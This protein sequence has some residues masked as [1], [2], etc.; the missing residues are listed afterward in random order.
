M[1][2]QTFKQMAMVAGGNAYLNKNFKLVPSNNPLELHTRD[3][4]SSEKLLEQNLNQLYKDNRTLAIVVYNKGHII[5]EKYRKPVTNSCPIF[6]WSMSKSLVGLTLGYLLHEGKIL[7]LD[8]PAKLYSKE[9]EGTVY[10]E[11]SIRNLLKMSSGVGR[12]ITD[13]NQREHEWNHMKDGL[14]S[15]IEHLHQ[16]PNIDLESGKQFNYSG[17]DTEAVCNIIDNNGGFLNTFQ[18]YIWEPAQT[19][20]AG[21]WM[22]EKDDR[23]IAQAGFSAVAR[24]WIRIGLHTMKEFNNSNESIR[25]YMK[26]ATSRQIENSYDAKIGFNKTLKY[27][28]YQT[29]VG[30]FGP[31][32]SYWFSGS[33]GLRLGIDPVNEKMMYVAAHS[34]ESSY[35]IDIY[36]SFA[37]LQKLS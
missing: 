34:C 13:G 8:H 3:I 31:S 22:L 2:K 21:Y 19:E 7:D 33:G 16:F 32:P 10:G 1:D 15:T 12:S 6:S 23:V 35:I 25:N 5:Y 17:T 4:D 30:D 36:K 28:G 20:S 14:Y 9:L 18:K 27:Y 29:W 26:E 37:D 24:D 11:S